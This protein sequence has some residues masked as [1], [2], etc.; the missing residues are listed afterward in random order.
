M[1]FDIY[2]RIESGVMECWRLEP[3]SSSTRVPFPGRSGLALCEI[4]VS[5]PH[6]LLP[7]AE[8]VMRLT[9]PQD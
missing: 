6:G 8:D 5:D 4:V 9:V 1:P 2:R 7:E 3:A